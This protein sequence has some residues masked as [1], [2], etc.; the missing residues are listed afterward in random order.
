MNKGKTIFSQLM[1]MLPQYEFQKCVKRYGGRHKVKSFSCLDQ[2]LCLAF[3]LLTYRESLRDIQACLRAAG[4]ITWGFAARC[5]ETPSPTPTAGETGASIATSR[6][7]LSAR[8][9]RCKP[10]TVP[11]LVLHMPLARSV[12]SKVIRT[13]HVAL[14]SD[15]PDPT[16]FEKLLRYVI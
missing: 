6:W 11:N 10:A 5:R 3:A 9:E 7:C 15:P 12:Y 14:P 1:E 2:F 13:D 16:C 4:S 8:T